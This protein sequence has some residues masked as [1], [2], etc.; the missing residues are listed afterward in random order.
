MKIS[1]SERLIRLNNIAKKQ[2]NLLK[3]SKSFDKLQYVENRINN[4]KSLLNVEGKLNIFLYI[5]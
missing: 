2:M 1:Q 4:E 3:N 5:M